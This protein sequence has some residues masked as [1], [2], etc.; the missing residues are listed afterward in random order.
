VNDKTGEKVEFE[1][2]RPGETGWKGKDHGHYTPPGGER[3]EHTEPGKIV[4][5]LMDAGHGVV[6]TIGEH[7]VATVAIVGTVA[8]VATVLTGGA[9]APT[10]AIIW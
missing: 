9:L 5:L 10:L 3:G 4:K 8:L 6:N 1:K 2:G 7:P